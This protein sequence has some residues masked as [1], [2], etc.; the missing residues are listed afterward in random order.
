MLLESFLNLNQK[1]ILERWLNIYDHYA[2]E[3]VH[4]RNYWQL[5]LWMYYHQPQQNDLDR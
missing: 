5:Y 3:Y 4:E 2:V 1:L